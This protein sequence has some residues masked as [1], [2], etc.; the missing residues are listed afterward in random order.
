MAGL[1]ALVVLGLAGAVSA[2][3][4]A[5]ARAQVAKLAPWQV[6]LLL[7]LSLANY[8]ARG[9][10]W[11]LFARHIGL[12][13]GLRANLRHFLGGF[14]MAVT[15]GRLG[16]LV[17]MRWIARE[18]GVAFERAAPLLLV[19]RASDLAA[20]AV[21]TGAA[22][23]A[24]GLRIAGGGPVLALA[25]LAAVLATRPRL[26]AALARLGHRATGRFGRLFAR[27]RRA[28]R[29]LA[30]FASGGVLLRGSVLALFGWLA[31]G[32]AFF[33]LLHWMGAGVSAAT[34]IAIFLFATLAG[35][36]TGA[37]G[38]LGGAEAA[39]VALLS[40]EGV[41]LAV[42]VPATV[43]IRLTTLWFAIAIGAAVFPVAERHSRRIS[44]AL[45]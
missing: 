42:S 21:L 36:L 34:A 17:R 7:L 43:L 31:E 44:D 37:P 11:H 2:T 41:P 45:D 29:A 28:A 35:G 39:M 18:T 23:L 33:L 22:V 1:L 10:R 27:L 16:E 30:P 4:W 3:G 38:G 13:L 9:L 5:E 8:A 12:G 25:L 24:S 19:D 40:L 14:A 20:M 32:L 26:L 6:G 15:P